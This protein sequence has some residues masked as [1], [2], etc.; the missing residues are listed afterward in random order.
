MINFMIVSEPQF[1]ADDNFVIMIGNP[2]SA[3]DSFMIVIGTHEVWMHLALANLGGDYAP[4]YKHDQRL[5]LKERPS[6]YDLKERKRAHREQSDH[7]HN[8]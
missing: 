3:D 4:Q 1:S 6:P 2:C 7:S 8:S 5:H